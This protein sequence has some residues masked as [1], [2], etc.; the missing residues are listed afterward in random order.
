MNEY[1]CISCGHT[2]ES[3]KV[4]SCTECGYNMFPVPY[5]RKDV[6]INEIQKFIKSL[7]FNKLEDNHFSFYREELKRKAKTDEEKDIYEKILKGYNIAVDSNYSLK[8]LTSNNLT[9]QSPPTGAMYA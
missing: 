1:K 9:I 2:K 5:E 3:E 7:M 4:C 6:L 8:R